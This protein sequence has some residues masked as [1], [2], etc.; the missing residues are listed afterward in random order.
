MFEGSCPCATLG[1]GGNDGADKI[2]AI[3][4]GCDSVQGRNFAGKFGDTNGLGAGTDQHG[5][6]AVA[7]RRQRKCQFDA[8]AC[9]ERD[10]GM[11]VDTG[12][13]YIAELAG[14]EL[15][16]AL[17]G[18]TDLNREVYFVSSRLP[19]LAHMAPLPTWMHECGHGDDGNITHRKQGSYSQVPYGIL[20]LHCG[21]FSYLG[22]LMPSRDEPMVLE[23]VWQLL[24]AARFP[25]RGTRTSQFD[26]FL[27]GAHKFRGDIHEFNANPK[28]RN[29]IA[30]FASGANLDAGECQSEPDI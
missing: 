26:L 17:A 9:L 27:D 25:A 8:G 16:G 19:A 20:A 14:M 10:A 2:N 5:H 6:A 28:P 21:I 23:L 1:G 11:K 30:N 3:N 24:V 18:Q 29:T 12:A 4:G 13:G 22:K 15:R 7:L